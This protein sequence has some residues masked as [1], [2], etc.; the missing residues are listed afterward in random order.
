MGASQLQSLHAN[1]RATLPLS[2]SGFLLLLTQGSGRVCRMPRDILMI[3]SLYQGWKFWNLKTATLL[4]HPCFMTCNLEYRIYYGWLTWN[5]LG[6]KNS[7]CLTPQNAR[8]SSSVRQPF[9]PFVSSF[10]SPG[11]NL[12]PRLLLWEGM[13]TCTQKP[14]TRDSLEASWLGFKNTD[15]NPLFYILCGLQAYW[16]LFGGHILKICF[17]LYFP[18]KSWL[19]LLFLSLCSVLTYTWLFASKFPCWLLRWDIFRFNRLDW[20]F[21]ATGDR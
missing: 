5:P 8:D 7:F 4:P 3:G 16:R 20:R 18:W 21:G 10:P 6:S 9:N 1:S 2:L 15:L 11:L 12:I 17:E 14:I 13:S 19:P